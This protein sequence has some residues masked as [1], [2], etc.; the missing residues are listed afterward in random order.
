MRG[1]IFIA[2]LPVFCKVIDLAQRGDYLG[3]LDTELQNYATL[4]HLQGQVIPRVRGYYNVW[5]LLRLLA[6]EDVCSAIPA[7]S[8]ISA[9]TK[10]R[11]RSA[12]VLI[13]AEGYV[14]GDLER[15]N[16]CKT[17]MTVF[18]VDLESL[19]RGTPDEMAAE[20]AQLDTL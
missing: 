4:Q 3:M 9:T 18:L 15:R 20:L 12:L 1:G 7:S 10:R 14:H 5:G 19:R 6:L 17:G 16:F 8:P 2:D 13:H 11:M